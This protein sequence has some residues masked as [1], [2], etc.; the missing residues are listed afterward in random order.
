MFHMG[1]C[2]TF[3]HRP[4]GW[5][6]NSHRARLVK[7]S[8][9]VQNAAACPVFNLPKFFLVVSLFTL[10]PSLAAGGCSHQI[11]N[12]GPG[13]RGSSGSR[14]PISAGYGLSIFFSL[15]SPTTGHLA[16]HSL[17]QLRHHFTW[18]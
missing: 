13:I 18:P 5:N 4:S 11:L 16:L 10:P 7:Y 1:R 2:P 17:W 6:C 8:V 12:S 14:T 9:Y 3:C 15:C